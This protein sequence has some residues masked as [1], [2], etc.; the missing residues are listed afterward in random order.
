LL[1]ASDVTLGFEL[2]GATPSNNTL[3][4]MHWAKYQRQKVALAWEVTTAATLSRWRSPAP[5]RVTVTIHRI[6]R[7]QLD[8]DNLYGGAKMLIDALTISGLIVDDSEAHIDLTVTQEIGAPPRT[9]V[10]LEA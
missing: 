7:K 3:L 4:R 8:R 2:P 5:D 10:V 1:A 6:G 9:R